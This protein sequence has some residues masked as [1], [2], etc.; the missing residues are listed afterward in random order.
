MVVQIQIIAVGVDILPQQGDVLVTGGNQFPDLL[1]NA[2]GI[3]AALPAP[4]IGYDAVGTEIVAAVHD[5]DPCLHALFPHHRDALGNGAVLIVH[6]EDPLPG[7]IDLPQKL[8]EL[9]QGMGAEHQIHMTVGFLH[10]LRDPLLLRHAA[11]QADQAIGNLAALIEASGARVEDTIK[12]VVFI[13]NMDDFGKVNEI[14]SKYFK[15][16]CPA[17]SCVEVAR[18]PKDVLIEIEAI[19][20]KN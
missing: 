6:G 20:A 2:L 15:T 3:T 11:A 14:Y 7:L 19:V 18:L 16:D 1:Q 12:T 13:K 4:D 10:P 5:A 17:R 9:P 8:R